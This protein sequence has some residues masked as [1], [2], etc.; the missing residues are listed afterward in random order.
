M[1][2]FFPCIC[3][4]EFCSSERDAC[5]NFRY[6]RKKRSERELYKCKERGGGIGTLFVE[7]KLISLV[8][9]QNCD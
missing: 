4:L 6:G 8:V 5:D 9:R 3:V 2:F 7:K 1:I